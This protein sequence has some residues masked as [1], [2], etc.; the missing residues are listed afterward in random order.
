M[1]YTYTA[2]S[3][4]A[5]VSLVFV[6]LLASVTALECG[7]RRWW[8]LAGA[9]RPGRPPRG[10]R[11]SRTCGF[12]VA[13]VVLWTSAGESGR[14]GVQDCSWS[15]PVRSFALR[16]QELDHDQE[17]GTPGELLDTD[18]LFSLS[19][20]SSKSREL[21]ERAARGDYE[22]RRHHPDAAGDGGGH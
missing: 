6:A 9:G 18:S 21:R 7:E 11:F 22:G 8:V 10:H 20:G 2:F 4:N 19:V 3:D 13:V 15:G 16:A 5:F 12:L 1:P 14:F 17:A